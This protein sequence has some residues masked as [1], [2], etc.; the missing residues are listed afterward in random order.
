[1]RAGK[2]T[3]NS[4]FSLS[5]PLQTPAPCLADALEHATPALLRPRP[6]F[7]SNARARSRA[8]RWK[9]CRQKPTTAWRASRRRRFARHLGLHQAGRARALPTLTRRRL[10]PPA[11]HLALRSQPLRLAHR[12]GLRPPAHHRALR[13]LARHLAPRLAL[14]HSVWGRAAR[15]RSFTGCVRQYCPRTTSTSS[16]LAWRASGRCGVR[17]GPSI[18]PGICQILR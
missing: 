16:G 9:R 6:F 10:R 5:L 7:C 8:R 1:M 2:K 11:H 12:R 15:R 3:C 18:A 14:R 4:F 13:R 17:S